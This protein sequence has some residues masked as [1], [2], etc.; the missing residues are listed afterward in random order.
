LREPGQGPAPS[1]A[2]TQR[3][4]RPWLGAF[5]EIAADR[6]DAVEAGFA[7]IETVHRLMTVH[8]ADSDLSRLSLHGLDGPVP[9]HDWT[10]LVLARALF[11]AEAS[12]GDFDPTIG[13]RMQGAGLIPR[14]P[15]QPPPD[16]RANWR[17]V[18]L[19][20]GRARLRRACVLDLGGI[21]KGFAVDVAAAAMIAAGARRGLINAGGDLRAFGEETWTIVLPEPRSRRPAAVLQI[22]QAAVATSALLPGGRGARRLPRRRRA[23]ASAT[24]AAPCAMD[25]DALTKVTLAGGPRVRACLGAVGAEAYRL[26]RAGGWERLA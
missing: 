16:P 6:L 1:P 5:V 17:D 20:G 10:A 14:H 26:D 3:R 19:Q 4:C 11:W 7:A 13:G 8:Q 2:L 18:S 15:G 22:S 24:V 23:W 9:L 25:A 21:A 12:D